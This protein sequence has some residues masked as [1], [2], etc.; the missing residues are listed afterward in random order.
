MD[1]LPSQFSMAC[2]TVLCSLSLP[3]SIEDLSTFFYNHSDLLLP[4][5]YN[6]SLFSRPVIAYNTVMNLRYIA[7]LGDI[8]FSHLHTIIQDNPGDEMKKGMFYSI[9]ETIAGQKTIDISLM[10]DV[11]DRIFH[12]SEYLDSCFYG[13][14]KNSLIL[15]LSGLYPNNRSLIAILYS[16]LSTDS[17]IS[18]NSFHNYLL[19]VYFLL[20]EVIVLESLITSSSSVLI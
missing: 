9:V 4:S 7:G 2:S 18:F 8:L 11:Y 13:I 20:N 1:E 17:T 14:T 19:H 10:V 3:S 16:I 5:S 15:F 12:L 6:P